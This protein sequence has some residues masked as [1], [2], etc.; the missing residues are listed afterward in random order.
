MK[1]TPLTQH[2]L[3]SHCQR[4]LAEVK[5]RICSKCGKTYHAFCWDRHGGCVSARC[6]TGPFN[7]WKSPVVRFAFVGLLMVFLYYLLSAGFFVSRFWS[8]NK[9]QPA[10]TANED[11]NCSGYLRDSVR[12]NDTGNVKQLLARKCAGPQTVAEGICRAIEDN[13]TEMAGVLVDSQQGTHFNR[14][15][16]EVALGCAVSWGK[17]ELVQKLVAQGADLNSFDVLSSA[18]HTGDV[19]F[20]K[21]LIDAGATANPPNGNPLLVAV[22]AGDRQMA[23]MLLASGCDPNRGE[24][25]PLYEGRYPE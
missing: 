14:G 1:N 23:Q 11:S 15:S 20:C 2:S 24:L 19:G 6:K 9:H 7:L 3:C 5:S 12:N 4:T 10:Q 8:T 16:G 21:G 17:K 25:S 22:R 13:N 18:V